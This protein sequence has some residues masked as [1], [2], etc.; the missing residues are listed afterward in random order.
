MPSS[1][2]SFYPEDRRML[3]ELA[4][5][6]IYF[7][8]RHDQPPEIEPDILPRVLLAHRATFVTLEKHRRL[9][10]CIGSLEA[11]RPLAEDVIHNAFAAAFG[12]PRFPPVT[13]EEA[14]QLEIH[15]SL[16]S[17]LEEIS[18]QSEATLLTEIRPRA[19]GLVLEDGMHRATFLPAVWEALP[20]KRDFLRQLKMKAGLTPDHWSATLKIYRYRVDTIG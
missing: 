12:D 18:F 10:G 15:L 3:L 1:E 2:L 4:R 5:E 16:L 13:A 7:G 19:D 8:V 17:P 14:E 6:S 9:R 20:D 11:R